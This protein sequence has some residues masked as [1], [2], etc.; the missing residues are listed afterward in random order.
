[1]NKKG[2]IGRMGGSSRSIRAISFILGLLFLVMGLIPFLNSM[3]KIGFNITGIPKII[4]DI[5][6]IVAGLL[7]IIDASKLQRY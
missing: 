1:M 5:I 7:L 3:G 2:F 6:L 4:F